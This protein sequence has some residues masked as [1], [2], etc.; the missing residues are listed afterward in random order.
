MESP[1]REAG[2]YFN[3]GYT[4]ASATRSRLDGFELRL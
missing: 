2:K 4:L 1:N 3:H